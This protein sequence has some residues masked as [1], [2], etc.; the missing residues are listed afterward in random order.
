MSEDSYKNSK[1]KELFEF[2][3]EHGY[4]S[5]DLNNKF[6]K[7]LKENSKN[8]KANQNKKN[9][10]LNKNNVKNKNDYDKDNN[11]SEKDKEIFLN[12]IKNLDCSNH[13]KNTSNIEKKYSKF[14]PNLKNVIP[15]DTLDLHGLTRERAL[16]SVKKFI[17]EAKRNK[18]KVILIIHGKGF[19]SENK[20][21]VLKDLVEYYIA[22]EGKYYIKY[23]TEAP[24]RLGGGG[25]KLIYLHSND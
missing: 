23:S 20:I 17:F 6:Q 4:F 16:H 2:Y 9:I 21:S 5:E 18:L 19:R 11:Y 12:A 10:N 13:I 3:L 7:K 22:T 25:A 15:Q 24:A 14:K 1:D 8:Q